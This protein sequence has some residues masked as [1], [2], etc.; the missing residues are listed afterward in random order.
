M[1]ISL[2]GGTG[3]IGGHI[4]RTLTAKGHVL[5]VLARGPSDISVAK[6]LGVEIITGDI[7]EEDAVSKLVKDAD[8]IIHNIHCQDRK[9]SEDPAAYL[10]ANVCASFWLLEAAR[11]AGSKQFIFTSSAAVYGRTFADMLLDERHPTCPIRL[12]GAY[13]VSVEAL[14]L[15]YHHQFKMN[16]VCIRPVYVYGLAPRLKDSLWYDLVDKL[17]GGQEIKTERA[18]N[19]V[20][21]ETVAE[22]VSLLVG[23]ERAAGECYNLADCYVEWRSM[24][25]LAAE[26]L[27]RASH[28]H[29][30]AKPATII[31]NKA[32]QLG[33]T[34]PG[35]PAIEHYMKDLVG[36][37]VK[38]RQSKPSVIL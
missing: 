5:R 22:T 32:R 15:A 8:V 7:E 12:Y 20:S 3:F 13:K 14:C 23:N 26:L 31:S 19:V 6:T 34:F 4:L 33:V 36:A 1:K 17:V 9:P 16:T 30:H 10:R 24:A 29:R 18:G 11:Q 21:V 25:E 37:V 38:A 28:A 27:G 2:T 35:F